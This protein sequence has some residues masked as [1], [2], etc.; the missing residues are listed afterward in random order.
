MRDDLVRTSNT[1]SRPARG[2]YSG[3]RLVNMTWSPKETACRGAT[4]CEISQVYRSIS[5]GQYSNM[6][7]LKQGIAASVDVVHILVT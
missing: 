2:G 4:V 6:L 5:I 7:E 1:S 3:Q